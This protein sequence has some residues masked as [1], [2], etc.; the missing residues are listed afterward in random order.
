LP[1]GQGVHDLIKRNTT[2][3]SAFRGNVSLSQSAL[4]S[5]SEDPEHLLSEMLT[6]C[7]LLRE[8][9]FGDL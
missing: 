6:V 9:K 2:I 5:L 1:G 8:A 3:F 7:G 4:L